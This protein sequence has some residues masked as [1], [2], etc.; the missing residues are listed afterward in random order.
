MNRT[1]FR[2]LIHK[3][4]HEQQPRDE[5]TTNTTTTTTIMENSE[6]WNEELLVDRHQAPGSVT[7]PTPLDNP[8]GNPLSDTGREAP[9]DPTASVASTTVASTTATTMLVPGLHRQLDTQ[10]P[11]RGVGWVLKML[12]QVYDDKLVAESA[13][14]RNGYRAPTMVEYLS[15]WASTRYG[16][17]A[18]VEQMCWDLYHSVQVY[19][20]YSLEIDTFGRF[21]DEEASTEELSFFLF[22]RRFVLS[23]LTDDKGNKNK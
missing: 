16:M 23:S 6:G 13:S 10:K 8:L 18:L 20:E 15:E 1:M 12:R 11:P 14:F 3:H 9:M 17:P 19:R 2:R 7:V 4:Q 5:T 21:I 22:T